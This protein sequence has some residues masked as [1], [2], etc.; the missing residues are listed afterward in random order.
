[1]CI[2]DKWANIAPANSRRGALYSEVAYTEKI[3]LTVCNFNIGIRSEPDDIYIRYLHTP[4]KF[5]GQLRHIG[6]RLG[7]SGLV[8]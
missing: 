2:S 7:I 4:M 3:K 5:A 6:L 1:M 8:I